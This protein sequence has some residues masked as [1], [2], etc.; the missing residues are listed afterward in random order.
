MLDAKI[1]HAASLVFVLRSFASVPI[2]PTFDA[3]SLQA[4][5]LI[6]TEKAVKQAPLV[7]K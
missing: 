5:G 4:R 6:Q 1:L 3:C 7:A 2:P